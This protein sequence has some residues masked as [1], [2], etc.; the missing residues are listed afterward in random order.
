MKFQLPAS[1]YPLIRVLILTRDSLTHMD[2]G[3]EQPQEVDVDVPAGAKVGYVSVAASGEEVGD[4]VLLH[5][6]PEP[7]TVEPVTVEPEPPAE[8]PEQPEQPVVAFDDLPLEG[9]AQVIAASMEAEAP[10]ETVK[11]EEKTTVKVG[12]KK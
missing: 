7:V 11:V 1:D 9:K 2:F 12:R 10:P 8:Q 4:P 5:A 3:G 6:E